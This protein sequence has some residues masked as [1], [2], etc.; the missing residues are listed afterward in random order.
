MSKPINLSEYKN[1]Q[2][3]QLIVTDLSNL[4]TIT[5]EIAEKLIP[6]RKYIPVKDILKELAAQK[7]VI[8]LFHKKYSKLMDENENQIS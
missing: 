2:K 8:R 7:L 6:Y 4:I 5:N 3:A 1:Y